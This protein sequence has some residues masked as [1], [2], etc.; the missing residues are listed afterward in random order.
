MTINY[1]LCVREK[2][3]ILYVGILE[4]VCQKEPRVES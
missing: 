4:I 3:S 2:F 1:I